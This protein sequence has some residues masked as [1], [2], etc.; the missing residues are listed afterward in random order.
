MV[1]KISAWSIRLMGIAFSLLVVIFGVLSLNDRTI[2]IAKAI[3]M[4]TTAGILIA[5][6]GLK[7]IG[8]LGQSHDITLVISLVLIALLVLGAMLSFLP[9]VVIPGVIAGALGLVNIVS[10]IWLAVEML[11]V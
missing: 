4:L 2:S 10:G 3:V 11:L 1:A 7:R 5:E 6:T 9:G 8:M